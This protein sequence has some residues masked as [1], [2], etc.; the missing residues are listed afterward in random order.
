[1]TGPKNTVLT[2]YTLGIAM[3]LNSMC[4]AFYVVLKEIDKRRLNILPLMRTLSSITFSLVVA[5][6]SNVNLIKQSSIC[7]SIAGK[8]YQ[9]M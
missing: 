8:L 4:A 6:S 9:I 7:V 2:E 5:G 3:P 1:M